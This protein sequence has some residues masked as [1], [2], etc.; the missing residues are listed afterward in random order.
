MTFIR[1]SVIVTALLVPSTFVI[2]LESA[3]SLDLTK[4][5]SSVAIEALEPLP[6]FA[7]Y[8][9]AQ[10]VP[11]YKV[12]LKKGMFEIMGGLGHIEES[13]EADR[14]QPIYIKKTPQTDFFPV[15]LAYGIGDNTS[16]TF[17][18]KALKQQDKVSNQNYEGTSEPQFTI[19]H[20]FRTYDSAIVLSGSYSPDVGPKSSISGGAT[21]TEGNT[22][23]GGA[24]G[25]GLGGYYLR[26]GPTILG[27]EAAYLYRDTR[28]ENH[29][30]KNAFTGQTVAQIQT[31]IE[32]GNEKTLRGIVELA[33]PIRIGVIFGRTWIE[34]EEEMPLYEITHNIRNSYFRNFM[35]G[36]GRIQINPR[37]S[38]LPT[39]TFTDAP[40]TSG[41]TTKSDQEFTTQLG[42]RYRF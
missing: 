11:A 34:Q 33:L 38:L 31:R 9:V 25:E 7:Y 6:D 10:L 5:D 21:R 24:S 35:T 23:S 1:N 27:G 16:I 19:A 2:A 41:L 20:T 42:L 40:D 4:A 22:L 29:E 37:L 18:G 14:G 36:Y 15:Q 26:L 39:L 32:G 28:I 8:T 3:R 13:K 30:T 12:A 17:S